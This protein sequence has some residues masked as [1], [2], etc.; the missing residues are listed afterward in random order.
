[1]DIVQ[2]FSRVGMLAMATGDCGMAAAVPA[3]VTS[4]RTQYT[5]DPGI[6]QG[7]ILEPR[8]S[9]VKITCTTFE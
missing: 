7:S 3:V 1:M 5:T 9:F 6:I 4:L 8:N 2:C